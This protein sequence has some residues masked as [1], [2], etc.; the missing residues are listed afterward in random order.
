M[1]Y[2]SDS[3][4]FL[5]LSFNLVLVVMGIPVRSDIHCI[6]PL[7]EVN[8]V[9]FSSNGGVDQ[10]VLEKLVRTCGATFPVLLVA[11]V[12]GSDS[13]SF[14]RVS[15]SSKIHHVPPVWTSLKCFATPP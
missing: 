14:V 10:L 7:H 15:P 11:L 13:P 9:L 8:S 4:H 5:H 3:K 12:L 6:L 2:D 1:A